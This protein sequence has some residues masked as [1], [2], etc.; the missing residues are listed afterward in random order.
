MFTCLVLVHRINEEPEVEILVINQ[1]RG[2][3]GIFVSAI[4]MTQNNTIIANTT[5]LGHEPIQ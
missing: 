5:D 2:F 3:L 4:I 1:Y